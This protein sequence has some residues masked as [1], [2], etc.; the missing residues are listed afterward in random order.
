MPESLQLITEREASGEVFYDF[1]CPYPNGC[2]EYGVPFSSIGWSERDHAVARG[3][4]HI[5]EHETG[6]ATPSLDEFR[7]AVGI[8]PDTAG[9]SVRPE[10]WEF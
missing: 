8:T 9:Q 3:K 1:R 2:G 10:D 4:Q 7:V 6:E 5:N